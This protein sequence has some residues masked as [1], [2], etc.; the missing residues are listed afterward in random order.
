MV[1]DLFRTFCRALH[2]DAEKENDTPLG[3]AGQKLSTAVRPC[4]PRPAAKGKGCG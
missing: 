3:P 4:R 2:I 1:T